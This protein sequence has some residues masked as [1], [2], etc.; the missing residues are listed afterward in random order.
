MVSFHR[1][2]SLPEEK[3]VELLAQNG[4]VLD[5]AHSIRNTEAILFAFDDFYVEM[6]VIKYTDEILSLNCFKSMKK[7]DAYLHQ[8]DIGEI[9]ALLAC[10]R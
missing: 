7:L 1:Y 9:T 2:R 5:L 8:V 10:S 3:Q 6:V 4:V